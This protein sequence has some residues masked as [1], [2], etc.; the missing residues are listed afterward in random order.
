MSLR[1]LFRK[2]VEV[3]IERM[4][5]PVYTTLNGLIQKGQELL[6]EIPDNG[7][8]IRRN[9]RIRLENAIGKAVEQTQNNGRDMERAIKLLEAWR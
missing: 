4:E 6:D 1:N 8:L 3:R 2:K 5:I 9:A 7:S